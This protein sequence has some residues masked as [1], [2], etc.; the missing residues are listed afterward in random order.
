VGID[1]EDTRAAAIR[2]IHRVGVTYPSGFD[3]QGAAATD[4]RINGTPTTYFI[5]H[6]KMLDF[7]EGRLTEREL[8]GYVR[9][10]FGL[11]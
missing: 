8:L 6:G 7:Y 1:E 5:S 3:P 10:V 2:F 4:F 11:S 9:Q